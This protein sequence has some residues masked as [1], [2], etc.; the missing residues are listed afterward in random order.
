MCTGVNN[1]EFINRE[2]LYCGTSDDNTGTSKRGNGCE[3]F[4]YL[5]EFK[6]EIYTVSFS[7]NK[8]VK[9]R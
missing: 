9:N 3:W 6:Q 4:T 5:Y 8:S 1:S 2:K 7:K